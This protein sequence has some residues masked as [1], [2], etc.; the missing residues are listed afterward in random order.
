[1]N[2]KF[3]SQFNKSLYDNL[4]RIAFSCNDFSVSY[5][6]ILLFAKQFIS[7][8]DVDSKTVLVCCDHPL[9]ASIGL[10]ISFISNAAYLPITKNMFLDT[11]L[12]GIKFLR[13]ELLIVYKEQ[14]ADYLFTSINSI[15]YVFVISSMIIIKFING[16]LANRIKLLPNKALV[17]NVVDLNFESF[18][19]ANF[20]YYMFTSGSTGIPKLVGVTYDNLFHYLDNV[21]NIFSYK[22]YQNH[23]QVCHPTFDL[24]IHEILVGFLTLGLTYVF[25]KNHHYF[26]VNFIND[27]EINYV[28]LTPSMGS[29]INSQAKMLNAFMPSLKVVLFCGEL[30][31]VHLCNELVELCPLSAIYNLYG[32]TET[33]IACM[34]HKFD[35]GNNYNKFVSV[36]IGYSFPSLN[37]SLSNTN[38]IIIA[39]N[40][41]AKVINNDAVSRNNE[42]QDVYFTGDFAFF[43]QSLGYYFIARKDD[44]WKISG[45]RFEKSSLEVL[46]RMV[47]NVDDI[48]LIFSRANESKSQVLYLFTKHICLIQKYMWTLKTYLPDEVISII[49]VIFLDEIPRLPNSKINYAELSKMIDLEV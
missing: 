28:L 34:Y 3:L 24:S 10:T 12:T 22:K 7:R 43:D 38:E 40:Q 19:R 23:L 15:N 35:S 27:K 36:P 1:M 42:D 6:E 9:V 44:Q 47:F 31:S 20:A 32:P 14:S 4:N 8:C 21:F 37:V 41:V 26:L 16:R 30:L 2:M 33:T 5:C 13:P 39:G 18:K 45:Y 11:Y 29:I 49:K 25:D 48:Y 17:P 46:L